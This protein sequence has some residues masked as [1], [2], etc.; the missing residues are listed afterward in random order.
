MAV[1]VVAAPTRAVTVGLAAHKIRSVRKFISE[2]LGRYTGFTPK[3]FRLNAREES[4][5]PR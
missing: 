3:V 4:S 2:H 5:G 1:L